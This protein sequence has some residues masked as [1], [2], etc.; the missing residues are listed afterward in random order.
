VPVAEVRHVEE[1]LFDP[2]LEAEGLV[3]DYDHETVG[4]Y[5]ALGAPLRMSATPFAAGAASPP[6]ARHTTALLAELGFDDAEATALR[7]CGA[8][9]AGSRSTRSAR[10]RRT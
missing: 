9:V 10:A 7:D 6:F 5:R 1:M 2:H 4:R 8:I 3:A